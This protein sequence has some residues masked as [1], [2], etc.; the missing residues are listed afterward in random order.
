MVSTGAGSNMS[1]VFFV[2][3]RISNPAKNRQEASLWLTLPDDNHP[4]EKFQNEIKNQYRNTQKDNSLN[5]P[6]PGDHKRVVPF[7]PGRWWS[8]GGMFFVSTDKLSDGYPHVVINHL[9]IDPAYMGKK[10]IV[11]FHEG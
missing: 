11:R 2:F 9:L 4:C 3:N 10:V 7:S 8:H 1:G 6:L 5:D